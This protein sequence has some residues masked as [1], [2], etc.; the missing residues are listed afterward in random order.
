MD[1]KW[2][3]RSEY[4]LEINREERGEMEESGRKEIFE[5]Q[6]V[7]TR[8]SWERCRRSGQES[9][10]DQSGWGLTQSSF[11]HWA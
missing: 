3:A 4:S 1:W 5:G 8:E 6:V 9:Y 2:L 11:Q 10:L 7:S